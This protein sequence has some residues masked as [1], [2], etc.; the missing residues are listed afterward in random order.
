MLSIGSLCIEF[1]LACYKLSGCARRNS[2]FVPDGTVDVPTE[3]PARDC[4]AVLALLCGW[5]PPTVLSGTV[6]PLLETPVKLR[7][8]G[9]VLVRE[10]ARDAWTVP[11][12]LV[13]AGSRTFPF[14]T[15][16]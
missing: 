14:T 15:I 8:S 5:I 6:R 7:V 12:T 13:P 2:I 4:R 16:S 1:D 9:E 3:T 11:R 10:F